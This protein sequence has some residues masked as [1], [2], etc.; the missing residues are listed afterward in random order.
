MT[1]KEKKNKIL[2]RYK[3]QEER[4][5]VSN[6]I[7]KAYKYETY[8]KIEYTNFLNLNEQKIAITVLNE[9]GID[10][11]IFSFEDRLTK[12]VIFF[13]P[14]Y[15]EINNEFFNE[16][17]SCIKITAKSC[18]KLKHKDYMGA[19]YSL[20]VKHEVIGDI[21]VKENY[22]YVFL[23]KNVSCYIVLNLFKVGNEEVKVEEISLLDSSIKEISY[24]LEEK[25]IIV[26]SLRVDAL[27]SVI[28]KK[29]RN[30]VKEKITKGDLYINDKEER[31]LSYNLKEGDIV[32]FRKCGKL[33]IGK[34]IRKT[35]SDRI[36]ISVKMYV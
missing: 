15:I 3:L 32:S 21:F 30:E 4:I 29:S 27:L 9:L 16:Y 13:V 25:E 33:Q 12:K 1:K 5:F 6:L 10:Y 36:V 20:G 34:V 26:A 19:I 2:E 22:G 17:I 35:R 7:D 23:F 11:K 28:Y 8:G 24:D 18:D 31:F 14:E